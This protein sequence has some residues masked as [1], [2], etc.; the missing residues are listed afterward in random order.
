MIMIIIS[1][2][3]R[4]MLNIFLNSSEF[5]LNLK[6]LLLRNSVE[7]LKKLI[8]MLHQDVM[9]NL[10]ERKYRKI[11]WTLH[12]MCYSILKTVLKIIPSKFFVHLKI[13]LCCKKMFV[14]SSIIQFRAYYF[15]H[16]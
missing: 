10:T 2:I 5:K 11:H 14:L 4:R 9:Y 16:I 8:A 12:D 15:V 1:I 3:E 7:N 6:T 13:F